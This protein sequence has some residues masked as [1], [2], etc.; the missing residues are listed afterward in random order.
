MRKH[1]PYVCDEGLRM[2][3]GYQHALPRCAPKRKLDQK[4]WNSEC[5]LEGV[6]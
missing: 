6:V 1:L 4:T 5:V 2:A 3:T